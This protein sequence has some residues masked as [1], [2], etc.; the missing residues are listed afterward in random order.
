M[1][2]SSFGVICICTETKCLRHIIASKKAAEKVTAIEFNVMLLRGI[3][4][5]VYWAKIIGHKGR[6]TKR[7]STSL[8]QRFH[9]TAM[10]LCK[11]RQTFLAQQNCTESLPRRGCTWACRTYTHRSPRPAHQP[12]SGMMNTLK[13]LGHRMWNEIRM[14]F[15]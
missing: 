6:K 3:D 14:K 8:F 9:T 15:L 13:F 2:H 4:A 12:M 10:K 1:T 5:T 11:G 7:C